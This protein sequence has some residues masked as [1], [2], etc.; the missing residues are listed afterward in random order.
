MQFRQIVD[1]L[2][3]ARVTF[4]LFVKLEG[5]GWKNTTLNLDQLFS[6]FNAQLSS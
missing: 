5:Q 1:L 2:F 3:Q 6:Q 4:P